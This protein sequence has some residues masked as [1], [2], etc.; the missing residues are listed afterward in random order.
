M[1]FLRPMVVRD[2]AQTEGLSLD[3]YDLMR[4]GQQAV[5]PVPSS[6][7]PVNASPVLPPPVRSGAPA[8][9]TP[10]PLGSTPLPGMPVP[11]ATTA[12]VR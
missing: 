2:A 10:A 12:P 7:V 6:V 9:T 5:Q 8:G 11:P 4:S 1:V 3:R